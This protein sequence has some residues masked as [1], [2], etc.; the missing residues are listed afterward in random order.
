MG[1]HDRFELVGNSSEEPV[2]P[3]L[4]ARY[5]ITRHSNNPFKYQS[6]ILKISTRLFCGWLRNLAPP[7]GWLKPYVYIYIQYIYNG[8]FSVVYHPS[9]GAGFRW[10]I[11]CLPKK[12]PGPKAVFLFLPQGPG[13]SSPPEPWLWIHPEWYSKNDP[14]W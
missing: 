9:T 1:K 3:I 4:E 5:P 6:K 11:H 13:P 10:P 8:M 2:S 7:K 14:Q 12:V